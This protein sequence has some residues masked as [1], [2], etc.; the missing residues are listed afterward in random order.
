MWKLLAVLNK[1]SRQGAYHAGAAAG[2]F[3]GN[4]RVSVEGLSLDG[5]LFRKLVQAIGRG[6]DPSIAFYDRKVCGKQRHFI[7]SFKRLCDLEGRNARIE[8]ELIST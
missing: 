6:R 4:S 5:T 7:H 2:C 8:T 3:P 1:L